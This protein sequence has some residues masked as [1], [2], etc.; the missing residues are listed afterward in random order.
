M[1][2][3]SNVRNDMFLSLVLNFQMSAMAGLGKIVHPATQKVERNMDEAKASI[4]N[5]EMLAEKTKG[6]LSTEEDSILQQILTDIR[7]NFVN[8]QSRPAPETGNEEKPDENRESAEEQK[9]ENE[10][11]NK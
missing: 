6:N 5:L 11:T 2:T 8:E 9:S 1:S 4:D 7:L 10:K 3:D